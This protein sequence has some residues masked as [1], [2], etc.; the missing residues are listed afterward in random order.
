LTDIPAYAFLHVVLNYSK[1]TNL[2][3]ARL[4]FLLV[5]ALFA[6]LPRAEASELDGLVAAL[7]NG[8][9]VIVFRHG[10][11]DD[12]QKDI[13]PFRFDDMSA[14]RQLNEKG[15]NTARDI[16][17][18]WKKLGVPIGEVYTSRLNRAVETGKLI[19]GKDVSP[20]DALTDSSSGS[21]SGMANPDGKNTKAGR[22]VRELVD[23][24][25]KPGFNNLAITHK[26]NI[27]DAFGKEY[28]DIREGEALVYKT[29]ASGQAV[30]VMRVQA[31][32]WVSLAGS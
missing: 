20:T 14:Q 29:S 5:A 31:G 18:A 27:T 22:A 12:S 21:A 25:P 9:H 26:T 19:A 16:G 11:T 6:V 4:F 1:E 23:A 24:P 32:Q 13:F 7:K 3:R 17:A 10:A 28:A 30:F 8:G 15:R 2:N